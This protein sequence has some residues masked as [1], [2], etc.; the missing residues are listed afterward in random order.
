MHIFNQ[1]TG[2]FY[3]RREHDW[4]NS[5]IANAAANRTARL[6]VKREQ[7]DS[8][9]QGVQP[10]KRRRTNVIPD[11]EEY[12]DDQS[13]LDEP[14]GTE[15]SDDEYDPAKDSASESDVSFDAADTQGMSPE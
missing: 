3:Y 5:F 1:P 12:E 15:S 7:A 4:F 11:S 10:K 8:S 13:D 9:N 6:A 14:F 2:S